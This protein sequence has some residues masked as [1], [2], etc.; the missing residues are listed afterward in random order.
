MSMLKTLKLVAAKPAP[1]NATDRN[2]EKLV[3]YLN[4]Q[5][6]LVTAQLAGQPFG[7]T[8]I[9]TRKDEAGNRTRVEAPR[10]VRRGWF[11]DAN[12]ALFFS[13]RYGAKPLE[14]AKGMTAIA[15]EKLDA[16]PGVID[17]LVSAVEA[18][19]LDS[20]VAAAANDRQRNF[21]GKAA[22]A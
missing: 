22:K 17:T 15:V 21:K 13:V 14:L 20:V 12:G 5:K 6:A 8:R 16:L 4:E 19:E 11:T 10:H 1:A 18:G 3:R 9:V 7:A 2:R